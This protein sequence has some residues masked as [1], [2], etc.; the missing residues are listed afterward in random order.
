MRIIS[1]KYRGKKI[2]APK[3]LPVRPTTDQA[4]ESLFN[5]LQNRFDFEDLEVLDLFS[6]TGNL[7][8]EFLSRGVIKVV[9]VDANFACV[10]F[11]KQ[12]KTELNLSNFEPRKGDVLRAIPSINQQFDLI[13]ADPPYQMKEIVDLPNLILNADILKPNGLLVIEHGPA[14]KFEHRQLFEHRKYGHVNFSF[15]NTE[16]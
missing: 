3:N 12:I 2:L 16:S 7:S 11:Q 14:T 1:G 10:G 6:G 8:Y 5:I 9:A 13:F 4:K 15:F